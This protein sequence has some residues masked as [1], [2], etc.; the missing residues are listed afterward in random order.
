MSNETT[1]LLAGYPGVPEVENAAPEPTKPVEIMRWRMTSHRAGW[2][3]GA[4][5]FAGVLLQQL[6]DDAAALET[7]PG[8]DALVAAAWGFYEKCLRRLGADFELELAHRGVD[9]TKL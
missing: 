1:E 3:S 6:A 9:L 4:A 7:G 2:D 5:T 8:R